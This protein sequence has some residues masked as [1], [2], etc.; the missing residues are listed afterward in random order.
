MEPTDD[1]HTDEELARRLQAEWDEEDQYYLSHGPSEE[2]EN[3]EVPAPK[4]PP[5]PNLPPRP[6]AQP[7][8]AQHPNRRYPDVPLDA[9]HQIRVL[10]LQPGRYG[11][12]IFCT[13]VVQDLDLSTQPT[14][15]DPKIKSRPE[16]DFDKPEV[17]EEYRRQCA[18]PPY[19]ALSYTWGDP[20][21]EEQKPVNLHGIDGFSV[22][23]NLHACLARLR[24]REDARRLWIDQLCIHQDN[25]EERAAQVRAM[26]HIYAQAIDVYVWLG[27][28]T[29]LNELPNEAD[30]AWAYR[31]AVFDQL[32]EAVNRAASSWWTR[33][34]V[35]QEFMMARREPMMCF[36]LCQV[37]WSNLVETLFTISKERGGVG[38]PS[39]DRF[40]HLAKG[41]WQEGRQVTIDPI[42][43][44]GSD[45]LN[46]ASMGL[47]SKEDKPFDRGPRGLANYAWTFTQTQAKDPRDKVYSLYGLMTDDEK[48]RTTVDYSKDV[49]KVFSEATYTAMV[50]NGHLGFMRHVSS[51]KRSD[52]YLPSWAVDFASRRAF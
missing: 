34:W 2:D 52:P 33:A 32:Q 43:L 42:K 45:L 18:D 16:A 36:G 4:L 51:R 11:G 7:R 38:A 49:V 50:V 1:F 27:D 22:T 24:K 19:V 12:D 15:P 13:L 5:R 3:D 44:L 28:T 17:W 21:P 10:E 41:F 25:L 26:A 9:T 23:P 8:D 31:R 47:D 29:T 39:A 6:A 35:V 20:K 14:I 40:K 46:Y 48:V 30:G 37:R